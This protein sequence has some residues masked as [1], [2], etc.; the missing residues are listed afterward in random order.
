MIKP[1]FKNII[2]HMKNSLIISLIIFSA[3]CFSSCRKDIEIKN[4]ELPV[5]RAITK[6]S[7]YAV[8]TSSHLRLRT[9]PTISSKAITILWRG[10]ILEILRKSDIRDFVEGKENYWYL[11]NYDGLKGWV[12]GSYID[13]Y[14]SREKAVTASSEAGR[15]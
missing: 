15:Q 14:S 1:G 13:I 12:F 8:I 11:I 10:Y 4:V 5:T 3:F 6:K 2:R 7:N 9:E